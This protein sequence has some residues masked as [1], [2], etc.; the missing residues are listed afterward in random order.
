MKLETKH[1]IT[2]ELND[3]ENLLCQAKQMDE[4]ISR[5]DFIDY[6]EGLLNAAVD[7]INKSE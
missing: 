2:L 6:I 4:E 3:R 5:E 1:Y 7:L